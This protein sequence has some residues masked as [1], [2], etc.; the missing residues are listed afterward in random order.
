MENIRRRYP[1]PCRDV[2]SAQLQLQSEMLSQIFNQQGINIR[3][4]DTKKMLVVLDDVDHVMQLDALAKE[5]RWFGP[6][7]RII[8][9]THK[10]KEFCK[11]TR[12]TIYMRS[13]RLW[14][15]VNGEIE[16]V[17]KFSYDALCDEDKDLFIYIACF[18]N[19]EWFE[20]VEEFLAEK[21]SN[22]RY[23]LRVLA[24]KSLISIDRG[25]KDTRASSMDQGNVSST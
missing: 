17:L 24:D 21:F 11:D 22:V 7:S 18:F 1:I 2:Y 10:I 3:H 25:S 14:S 5:A 12:L 6:G 16:C 13:A 8:M 15:S 9:T 4:L 20:R 19:D 23:G